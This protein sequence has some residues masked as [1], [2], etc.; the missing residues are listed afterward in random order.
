MPVMAALRYCTVPRCGV[1]VRS[2]KCAAHQAPKRRQDLERYGRAD[3]QRLRRWHLGQ[4]PLCGQG[5]DEAANRAASRCLRDSRVTLATDVD[6]VVPVEM[7]PSRRLDPTNLR[8]L[9]SACHGHRT[10][11]AR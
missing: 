2:G 3:W 9:C 8:S 11:N 1:K 7:N 10:L 4:Y 6:H 5:P